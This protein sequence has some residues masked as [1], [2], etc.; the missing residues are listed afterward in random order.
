MQ[1]LALVYATEDKSS[2]ADKSS[3]WPNGEPKSVRDAHDKQQG[4][5]R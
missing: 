4:G 2:T 5:Q 3:S 1:I